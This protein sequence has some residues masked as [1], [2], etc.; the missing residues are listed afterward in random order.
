MYKER[1][2]GEPAGENE[3]I[4]VELSFDPEDFRYRQLE[5][6]AKEQNLGLRFFI[7]TFVVEKYFCTCNCCLGSCNC[8]RGDCKKR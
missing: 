6:E 5:E 1:Y 4:K 3:T 2:D 8:Y 7:Q